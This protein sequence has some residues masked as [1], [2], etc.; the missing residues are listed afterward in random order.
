MERKGN[1]FVCSTKQLLKLAVVF[2]L[3]I[4]RAYGQH[5]PKT[6]AFANAQYIITAEVAS[7]HSFV[8]NFI[9]LSDFVI[10]VQPNEFIYKG[11]SGRFYIGQV[12][13]QE[14][15]DNRGETLK[16]AASVLLKGR[17]FSG[18]TVL[19]AF[20]ELDRIEELS[21]RI[22]AKRFYLQ[23]LEKTQFEILAAKV[24]E[25][26]LKGANPREVLQQANIA[27]TGSVKST[28][29]TSEW[30]RDWSGLL[31]TDGINVPKIIERPEITATEEARR[32]RISGRIRLTAII[33]RN[34]GI[35]DIK[36]V[37]GLGHGLDERA[38]D[39]V[40]NSWVFLPA[41][42][43]GEVV[44]TSASF[45]LEILPPDAKKP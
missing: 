12:Y 25:L 34:G 6:F 4:T 23:A 13:E 9:N 32:S 3:C 15:K 39:A 40:R 38:L 19:G 20:H 16:Y 33:S 21:I 44:E 1:V 29:G 10:V 27:E 37:K 30:D 35:Q 36:V 5:G 11:V 7:E 2:C 26:D 22:G 31:T 14:H 28:D 24:G 43:N 41:T 45:D 18:L 42:K 8:V 17:A